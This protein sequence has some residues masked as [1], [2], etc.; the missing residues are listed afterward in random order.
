MEGHASIIVKESIRVALKAVYLE[1]INAL[2]TDAIVRRVY[3]K[4]CKQ[5]VAALCARHEKKV[6]KEALS[7]WRGA[8]LSVCGDG[9]Q[10][11]SVAVADEHLIQ[12][13]ARGVYASV[14][15]EVRNAFVGNLQKATEEALDLL[16][17]TP[18]KPSQFVEVVCSKTEARMCGFLA[19]RPETTPAGCR[20]IRV[21]DP[22]T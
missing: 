6:C 20:S 8:V 12:E 9:E 11:P 7:S 18:K 3:V 22:A 1:N 5:M 16:R 21:L 15:P 10:R 13:L 19:R 14:S 2:S 4:S 17:Y